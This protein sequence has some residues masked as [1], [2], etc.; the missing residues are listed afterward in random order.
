MTDEGPVATGRLG[1]RLEWD[2]GPGRRLYLR[3]VRARR[4]Y[5]V[6]PSSLQLPGVT[7]T[8]SSTTVFEGGTPADIVNGALVFAKGSFDAS[9][10]SLFATWIEVVKA[11]APA[12][13][14]AGTV[15]DFVSL[16][17]LRIGGQRVDASNARYVDG[18]PSALA[19][20][21]LVMAT[22]EM[23]ERNGVRVFVA[24]Q[25]RFMQ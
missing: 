12:A 16:S 3:L 24:T 17:D 20:G 13:R 11:G 14:V 19:D 10:K 1:Y 6:A 23:A 15:S 25:V 4:A 18:E 9:S 2:P 5:D 8:H 21:R 22:G 7:I